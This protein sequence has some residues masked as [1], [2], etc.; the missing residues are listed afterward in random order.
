LF[1]PAKASLDEIEHLSEDAYRAVIEAE[2]SVLS[3]AQEHSDDS[4]MNETTSPEV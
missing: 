4:F 3:F 1:F 2:Q